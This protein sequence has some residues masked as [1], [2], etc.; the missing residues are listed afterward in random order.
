MTKG[1]YTQGTFLTQILHK[2]NMIAI[3][4]TESN[5]WYRRCITQ[6]TKL[7]IHT[8]LMYV[9]IECAC[10]RQSL[11]LLYPPPLSQILIP[12]CMFDVDLSAYATCLYLPVPQESFA[13]GLLIFRFL[14][15][16]LKFTR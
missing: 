7:P 9:F 5:L 15:M 3:T 13:K 16:S 2:N 14:P 1:P 10:T 12:Q 8:D 11:V 6:R 4:L